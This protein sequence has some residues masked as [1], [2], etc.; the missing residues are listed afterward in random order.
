MIRLC[1]RLCCIV[2]IAV[3][4][5]SFAMSQTPIPLSDA[6]TKQ[7]KSLEKGAIVTAESVKG[8]V[9]FSVAGALEPK[10]IAPEKVLY[11]IG[12]IS[13]VF[14]GLLLAQA[15]V[16]KKLTLDT[17]L[18]EVMGEEQKFADPAVA[19][20]TLRQL[21]THTSGLPRLPGLMMLAAAMPNPYA[22]FDR[23]ML[24]LA[25]AGQKLEGKAPYDQSYSNYGMGLL[26]DLLSRVY[27]K[28]WEQ[29][30]KERITSPL[31]MNDTVVTL[32]EEQQKRFAPP[33]KGKQ[34]G[35]PWTFST[36]AGAGALRSTAADMVKFGEALLA[37]EKTPF[38]E[39][40]EL[41]LQ[42]HT[43]AKDIG[44]AI[45]ISKLDGQELRD[46][47]GGTGGYRSLLQVIPATQGVRV[48]L[49]NNSA[50]EPASVIADMRNEK[51]RVAESD[52]VLTADQLAE[53]EGVY[54]IDAEGRFTVVRRGDQLWTQLTM[55]SFLQLFPHE[56]EDRFFLK[57]VAAEVQFHRENGKIVSLTNHQNGRELTARK[58]DQPVPKF[59]FRDAKELKEF[60]GTYDLNAFAKFTIRVR[61]ETLHVQL[62]GQPSL[63]VFER[64]QDRFEYDAVEAALEFERD[65]DGKIVAVKLHQNGVVQRAPKKS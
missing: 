32:S 47:G 49:C 12:S 31:G 23:A 10:D 17:T 3:N 56:K 26:G 7:A 41:M 63:P 37:P 60:T 8:E 44:L 21:A 38:K 14:T 9:R 62:T 65:K 15:V 46:H 39:A 43:P 30:V 1:R 61:G 29:L 34:A 13:K 19:S 4:A 22:A 64:T 57:V 52:K 5:P 53:Y 54:P 16:E 35:T 18:R 36:L 6:A 59:I 28:P 48:I 58:S 25:V 40:I 42:P 27:D 45:M 51:P 24:K 50:M 20:I 11:E 33:Y 2:A 55:Q